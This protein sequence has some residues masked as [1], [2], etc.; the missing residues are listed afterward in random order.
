MKRVLFITVLI[1]MIA[2][3]GGSLQA[4]PPAITV[5]LALDKTIYAPGEQI[6]ATLSLSNAGGDIITVEGFSARDFYLMLQFSDES[7]TVVTSDQFSETSTP[8]P[9]LP[10]VFPAASGELIQG[11]LIEAIET[12][13]VLAYDP[14][15]VLTYYANAIAHWRRSTGS[16]KN[17][18]AYHHT[19][20]RE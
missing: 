16:S 13:W 9:A 15:D 18:P 19:D 7:G 20:Q 12:G 14:F 17:P 1:A 4:A 6:L 11:D 8:F 5:S 10:R 2:L 3:G